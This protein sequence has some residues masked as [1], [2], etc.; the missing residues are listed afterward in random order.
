[1]IFYTNTMHHYEV[2]CSLKTNRP[3]A[4]FL[5]SDKKE[6]A[7]V[8]ISSQVKTSCSQVYFNFLNVC[9]TLLNQGLLSL[10]S[11]SFMGKVMKISLIFISTST[12]I[13]NV[14]LC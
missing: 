5:C 1:M 3:E 9:V 6:T 8:Y 10:S 12:V 13:T 7:G 14:G 4:A 2:T 11:V